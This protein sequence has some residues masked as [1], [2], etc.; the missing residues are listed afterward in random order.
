MNKKYNKN[1][2]CVSVDG[3]ERTIEIP[4]ENG[5][6]IKYISNTCTYDDIKSNKCIFMEKCKTDSQCLSI[7][8]LIN[9]VYL[10]MKHR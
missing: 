8:V 3:Y 6:L 1:D 4:D 5:N 9:I 10:M 7:N 2:T